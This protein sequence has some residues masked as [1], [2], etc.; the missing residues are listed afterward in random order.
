MP[1]E[2]ALDVLVL[3]SDVSFP[4]DEERIIGIYTYVLERDPNHVRANLGRGEWFLAY[5]EY[6]KAI[7]FLRKVLALSHKK[8]PEYVQAKAALRYAEYKLKK[9]SEQ[10][11]AAYP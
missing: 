4:A 2:I 9:K 6:E 10:C 5:R 1:P 7:P 3:R 8:S 11:S